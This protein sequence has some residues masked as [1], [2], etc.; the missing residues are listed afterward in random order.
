MLIFVLLDSFY[1][2]KVTFKNLV[3]SHT[4]RVQYKYVPSHADNKKKWLD[5]SL[6]ERINIKVD[7]LAKKALKAAHCPGKYIK[8]SYPNKQI[9]IILGGR[10]AMVLAGGTGRVLGPIDR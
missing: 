5:C 8:S 9:W 4:F 6:K 10:K 1:H 3:S 2:E 7:R